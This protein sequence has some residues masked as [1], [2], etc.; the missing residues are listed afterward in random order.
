MTKSVDEMWVNT[1]RALLWGV[2]FL[3]LLGDVFLIAVSVWTTVEEPERMYNTLNMW[4]H[5][6]SVLGT[7]FYA[8]IE[9]WEMQEEEGD[10]EEGKRGRTNVSRSSR[11]LVFML[12][13][14]VMPMSDVFTLLSYIRANNFESDS[15]ATA[16]VFTA[17][18]LLFISLV[19]WLWVIASS[20]VLLSMKGPLSPESG[21]KG[22]RNSEAGIKKRPLL[23]R[24]A[25]SRPEYE[26]RHAAPGLNLFGHGHALRRRWD[27]Y[28]L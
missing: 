20:V 1:L 16:T 10:E 9:L 25:A 3:E 23:Q 24:S 13:F 6:M 8:R 22:V 17:A 4:M 11:V 12:L 19:S 14:T 18:F 27:P 5:P 7:L 21:K 15:L 26:M 2:V 28:E